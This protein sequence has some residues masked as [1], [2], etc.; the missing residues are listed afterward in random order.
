[1]KSYKTL[2]L[3]IFM[4]VSLQAQNFSFEDGIVPIDWVKSGGDVLSISA[5]HYKDDNYS[6]KWETGGNNVLEVTFPEF[7]TTS[8]LGAVLQIYS[9]QISDAVLR[10]EFISS[11]N[12]TLKTA[13]YR[14][15][16]KGWRDFTRKYIDYA[17]TAVSQQVKKVR[18]KVIPNTSGNNTI[19]FDR[20]I[21]NAT[22]ENDRVPG[23]QWID[24]ISFFATYN[25]TTPLTLYSF[26]KDITLS[27]ATEQEIADL[28]LLRTRSLP[29]PAQPN[30]TVLNNA[31]NFADG[32][33]I[34]RNADGT[35]KGKM[36]DNLNTALTM[37]TM[38]DYAQKLEALAADFQNNLSDQAVIDRFNNFFDH[39]IEQ[40]IAEGCSFSIGT[41]DY[42]N[43]RNIPN[44]L[45]NVLPVCSDSQKMELIKLVNWISY[46]YTMY[47][48]ESDYLKNLNSDIVYLFLPY[49]TTAAVHH[50][51]TDIAVRELKALKRFLDRNSRYVPGGKDIL[52]PDGTGFHHNTHYNNYMYSYQTWIENIHL[53]RGTSFQ[54]SNDS[55]LRI[56]K[57]IVSVYK[58]AT[59]GTGDT[60][61]LYGLALSGRNPFESGQ[62]LFFTR[63][64]FDKLIEIGTGVTGTLDEEL[65]GAYNYFFQTNT[66]NVP[67]NKQEGF[68]QF[69]YSPLAI[70]RKNNWVVT[71]R[72]PTTKFWGAEIYDKQN[73]FGRYQSHGTLEVMY[74]G[75]LIK[76]GYPTN[77]HGGGWDWN[78]PQGGTTVKYSTWTDLMPSQNLT[79]RFDQYAKT[80]NFAGALAWGD[81]GIFAADFDQDDNWGSQR[82]TPTNLKFKKS[83]FAYNGMI[84]SLGSDISATGTYNN[85][86]NTLTTVFQN[87]Y[88]TSFSTQSFVVNGTA[89]TT[90]GYNVSLPS[91]EDNW[92][93]TPSGTGFLV[94]K[95]NENVNVNFDTQKTPK[96]DGSDYSNPA[97]SAT[98]AK[99]FI[100]HGVKPTKKGY[101][102]I[103]IP[104]ATNASMQVMTQNY[105][106]L[107]RINQQNSS[108]HSVTFL[109]DNI[110]AY[111]FFEP[112]DGLNVGNVKS[113]N[114]RMLLMEKEDLENNSIQF[115]A[116]CP[117]LNPVSDTDFGWRSTSK[118]ADLVLVGEW[119]LQNPVQGVVFSTPVSGETNV[120]LTFSE[121]NPVYFNVKTFG[122]K[123]KNSQM[124]EFFTYKVMENNLMLYFKD[125]SHSQR[126]LE[127][128]TID[129]KLIRQFNVS[130]E[131]E[132]VE[133]N[134]FG[135]KNSIYICKI[136]NKEYSFSFKIKI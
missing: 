125:E 111:T 102:F 55:Y 123:V 62:S 52:K 109:Q 15:N 34:T 96:Q 107:F 135:E 112:V 76:S 100:N 128:Y 47:Y 81:M 101:S 79:A 12:L 17:S 98:V 40:G 13:N 19:Y 82:F 51:D 58:M 53:L 127:L 3:F 6:L 35:V 57:A 87:I 83:M 38:A 129:G 88:S 69:N 63:T 31:R 61:R 33:N 74:P 22:I 16:Y 72:A 45:L 71:M 113:A 131:E 11:T 92:F 120:S 14:L 93:I 115:A 8:A 27:T 73:R 136:S 42:T 4:V 99:V 20:V 133:M 78:M 70:Y 121:G 37:A 5:E 49:F 65:A 84:V 60:N 26:H 91:N 56:K 29:K 44:R 68:Y 66:Y 119:Q 114:S 126:H 32:L 130:G 134:N 89:V 122:T 50:P 10:V 106:N 9:T 105:Q 118:S 90:V 23:I 104:A 43:A 21:F 95:G 2:L 110:N 18:F 54:I 67:D 41:T 30:S 80:K 25:N 103:V 85:T 97:T 108:M 132:I 59:L 116:S 36:I 77:G 64:L 46:Y 117:D 7:T 1:M 48:T 28:N 124:E 39:L 75:N 94:P 86:W 24:D